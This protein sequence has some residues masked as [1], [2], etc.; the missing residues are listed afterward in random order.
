MILGGK[1]RDVQ[2]NPADDDLGS[3]NTDLVDAEQI[4]AGQTPQL[5]VEILVLIANQLFSFD[6]L[7]CAGTCSDRLISSLWRYQSLD[8]LIQ[9]Y[10]V[11]CMFRSSH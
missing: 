11:C 6:S 3:T 7:G 5:R 1:S 10:F 9:T 4:R 8:L 2:A